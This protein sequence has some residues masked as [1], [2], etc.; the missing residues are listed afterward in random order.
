M[1][2][3]RDWDFSFLFLFFSLVISMCTTLPETSGFLCSTYR[4]SRSTLHIH[5]CLL[6][7]S[8]VPSFSLQFLQCMQHDTK[9]A[10]SFA[11]H[12]SSL[13]TCPLLLAFLPFSQPFFSGQERKPPHTHADFPLC[14][15]QKQL[16]APQPLISF[17]QKEG[18]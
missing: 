9:C 8:L 5:E 16:D 11:R 12:K 2:V 15:T 18:G 14:C 3:H 13:H 6:V 10:W 1:N 17:N 4:R 7:S